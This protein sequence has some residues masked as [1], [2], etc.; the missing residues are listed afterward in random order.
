VGDGTFV[1]SA[2]LVEPGAIVGSGTRVWAFAHILPGASVGHDCNICDHVFIEGGARVG[3]RVTIKP[4]VQLWVGITL[5][6]DVFVGPNATF[7]NDL[8][9]RSKNY[10]VERPRTAVKRRASIGANATVLAGITIGSN[11]MVGAGAVVTR[12]VP[13]NAIVTGN[14]ARIVG[15]VDS[16]A[17]T[18]L[19]SAVQQTRA[20]G[21][22]GVRGARLL[23]MPVVSDLRGNLSFGEHDAH[24][25]FVPRRY[26]V[27]YDV[28]GKE[29]RGE[30]AHRTLHQLMICAKGSVSVVLDDGAVR[31]EVLLDRPNLALHV[32]P[33]I[34]T[35]QYRYSND[36]VFLVLASDV[37]D[38]ADYIRD[39]DEFMKALGGTA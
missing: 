35:T 16:R 9:P 2:A 11:A 31:D 7:T 39:Y 24:L 36:A 1:H 3:D 33:M 18:P 26:F 14:P 5:E 21:S 29:V 38:D 4:G 37:Y 23:D 13:P 34:W 10:P 6:D 15:Y 30:H 22:L 32:P 12:D 25:P 27:V 8:F 19:S 28:P 20:G 17:Q